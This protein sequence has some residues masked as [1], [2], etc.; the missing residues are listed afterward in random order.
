M[1]AAHVRERGPTSRP[2][3]LIVAIAD[4]EPRHGGKFTAGIKPPTTVCSL[5]LIP[6][7][8]RIHDAIVNL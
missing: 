8:L 6:P 4:G 3:E 2:V 1:I 5:V 7:I